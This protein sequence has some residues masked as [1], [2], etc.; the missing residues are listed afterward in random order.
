MARHWPT[1]AFTALPE[2]PARRVGGAGAPD[3]VSRG[4]AGEPGRASAA[5]D[6][7]RRAVVALCNNPPDNPASQTLARILG[8]AGLTAQ[9]IHPT[10]A[11]GWRRA[12]GTWLSPR[13]LRAALRA[14][15][16]VVH[17]AF[18]LQLPALCVAALRGTPRVG[19]LWDIY[20][21]PRCRGLRG[22]LWRWAEAAG[23]RLAGTV[24]VPSADYVGPARAAGARTVLIHPLPAPHSHRRPAPVRAPGPLRIGYA[25]A[26]DSLR[27]PAAAIAQHVRPGEP[28][29]LHAFSARPAAPTQ[30]GSELRIVWRGWA[31]WPELSAQLVGLDYGLVALDPAHS[32]PAF[33]QKVAC[34][35]AAGLPVLLAGP[36]MPAL[37]AFLSEHGVGRRLEGPLPD[38]ACA[39][40]DRVR[41]CRGQGAALAALASPEIPLA[42]LL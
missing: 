19:F 17:S 12:L 30:P 35:L 6:S 29:E 42:A 31:G 41:L 40:A 37:E 14:D 25:G 33:P 10:A 34:Y 3:A 8:D 7:A 15:A 1:D 24:L 9:P 32:G 22:R 21:G 20:P 27:D 18:A 39:Q 4:E 28:V 23:L 16:L 2:R 26:L 13:A 5:P 36:P 11:R 38:T